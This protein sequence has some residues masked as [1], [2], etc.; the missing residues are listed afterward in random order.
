M[1]RLETEGGDNNAWDLDLPTLPVNSERVL[2]I[3]TA[4]LVP[5]QLSE[6]RHEQ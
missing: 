5:F 1:S 6:M 2:A 3:D 4:A